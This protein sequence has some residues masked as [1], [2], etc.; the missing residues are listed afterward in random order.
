M[1]S[2][3]FDCC[4]GIGIDDVHRRNALFFYRIDVGMM[5]MERN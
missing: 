5:Q 2:E 3:N 1:V 4:V